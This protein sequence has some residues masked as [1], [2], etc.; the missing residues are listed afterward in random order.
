MGKSQKLNIYNG[1]DFNTNLDYFFEG[2]DNGNKIFWVFYEFSSICI[3]FKLNIIN[4]NWSV[5]NENVDIKELLKQIM[6]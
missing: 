3:D 5:I 2:K 1:E 4:K 6:L